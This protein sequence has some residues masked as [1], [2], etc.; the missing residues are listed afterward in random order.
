LNGSFADAIIR[1]CNQVSNAGCLYFV[2]VQAQNVAYK[3]TTGLDADLNYDLDVSG[4]GRFSFG[5]SATYLL[6]VEMQESIFRAPVDV[7]RDGQLGESVRF[8]GG[9]QLGWERDVWA[10]NV[11]LNYI[12]SF[13]PFNTAFVHSVGS[14]TTVNVRLS[15]RTPWEGELQLGVN[16]V[17]DRQPPLDLQNGDT[18]LTFYHQQFHDVDGAKWYA[19]YRHKFGG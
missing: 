16:N 18:S 6:D 17:F 8:K 3:K 19:G 2:D 13:T 4:A 14:Y 10:A 5:L 1:D 15:Y 9:L 7:L 12:G 11:F